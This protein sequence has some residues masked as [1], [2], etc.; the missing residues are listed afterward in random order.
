MAKIACH[1]LIH[2]YQQRGT[3]VLLNT[4]IIWNDMAEFGPRAEVA[5]TTPTPLAC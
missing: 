3:V 1:V 2:L 4:A 5:V